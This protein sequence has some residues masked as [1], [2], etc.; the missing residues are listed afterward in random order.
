DT[1][2]D[3]HQSVFIWLDCAV[4]D[5]VHVLYHFV[6]TAIFSNEGAQLH[7]LN[8]YFFDA[9]ATVQ[10]FPYLLRTQHFPISKNFLYLNIFQVRFQSFDEAVKS[11]FGCIRDKRDNGIFQIIIQSFEYRTR[12]LFTQSYTLLV[13]ACIRASTEINAL[14]ATCGV[15]CLF[16]YPLVMESTVRV[17]NYCM[18]W[19]QLLNIFNLKIESGLYSRTLRSH[20]NHFIIH[21]IK[22]RTNTVF[23]SHYKAAA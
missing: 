6:S 9:Y 5:I 23:I 1:I 17:N 2:I 4:S 15:S 14:K 3:Y 10:Q 21:I 16:E 8:G 7:I 11:N 13:N 19:L 20:D 18:A 22:C 12:Q